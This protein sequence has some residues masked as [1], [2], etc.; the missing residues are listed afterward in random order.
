M[1]GIGGSDMKPLTQRVQQARYL[2]RRQ[3]L[4]FGGMVEAYGDGPTRLEAAWW[5]PTVRGGGTV[6]LDDDDAPE[7]RWTPLC[8]LCGA[9]RGLDGA[10]HHDARP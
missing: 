1:A 6:Y 5:S 9:P 10:C 4:S 7:G 8:R 2:L 3:G